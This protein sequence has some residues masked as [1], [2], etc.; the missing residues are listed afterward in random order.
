MIAGIECELF[1]ATLA[2]AE[3]ISHC[4]GVTHA[5]IVQ[6]LRVEPRTSGLSPMP[7]VVFD[8][9]YGLAPSVAATG[10]ALAAAT[11]GDKVLWI[12][13]SVGSKK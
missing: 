11:L 12:L 2:G 4:L 10:L 5:S 6:A 13:R 9:E 3:A 8:A 1:I 7:Y